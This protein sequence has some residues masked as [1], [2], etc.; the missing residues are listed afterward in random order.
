[1][2]GKRV[3]VKYQYYQLC[4]IMGDET[5]EYTFDLREWIGKVNELSLEERIKEL[6]EI[7]GRLEAVALVCNDEFYVLNFMRLDVVSN[8]YVLEPDTIA[9]HV[10][11]GENEYIGKNTVLLYDPR[12]NVAMVQCNRGSYGVFAL[13]NYINSFISD[14]NLCYFRPIDSDYTDDDL[15]KKQFL[16]LDVRFA[17]TRGLVSRNSTAFEDIIKL[18]N[19]VECKTAHLEFGLGYNYGRRDELEAET[20]QGIIKEIRSGDNRELISSARIT[21]SDDQKS[22]FLI[23]YKIF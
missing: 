13:Q 23:Y 4:T 6:N 19:Q 14:G 2:D 15:L 7:S 18:C 3:A 1:M 20:M 22:R 9:K 21:L 11:L 16:K 5:T 12:Y 10:D 17:N 8:T